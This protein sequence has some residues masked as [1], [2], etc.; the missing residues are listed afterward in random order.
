LWC[1]EPIDDKGVLFGCAYL[2]SRPE[3]EYLI[4]RCFAALN[5][6]FWKRINPRSQRRAFT[7]AQVLQPEFA[8]RERPYRSAAP[9]FDFD[10]TE[11]ASRVKKAP[12]NRGLSTQT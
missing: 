8:R 5:Q 2:S 12:V 9:K 10:P 6:R 3:G 4:F 11:R 1:D 7:S